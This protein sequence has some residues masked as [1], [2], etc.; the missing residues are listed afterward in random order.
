[1]LEEQKML[2][3]N[4]IGLAKYIALRWL[5]KTHIELDDLMGITQLGLVKA[6]IRYDE[7]RGKFSIFATTVME[8]EI[9][10]ELRNQS[11]RLTTESLNVEVP[12][13]EGL[14]MTDLIGDTKDNYAAA[15][16][17][18]VIQQEVKRLTAQERQAV[19]M[20]ILF[21]DMKQQERGKAMGIS[22]SRYSRNLRSAKKKI[23]QLRNY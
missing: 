15:E 9:I 4:N 1:M 7:G 19:Y 16:L 21:P 2:V 3:I 18:A 10:Q 11:K 17:A 20:G 14:E 23:L 8:N 6:A 12:G 5:E 22:Q 13:T